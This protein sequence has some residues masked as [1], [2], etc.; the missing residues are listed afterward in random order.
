MKKTE[1]VN[2]QLQSVLFKEYSSIAVNSTQKGLIILMFV[3]G[4]G[5]PTCHS[6]IIEEEYLYFKLN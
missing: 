2:K 3:G 5:Y 6:K 4:V 1:R